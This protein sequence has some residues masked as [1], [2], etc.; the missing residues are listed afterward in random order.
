MISRFLPL[1]VATL[2]G[3]S[4]FAAPIEIPSPTG[5]PQSIASGTDPFLQALGERGGSSDF[6][7]RL[8]STAAALPVLGERT[9]DMAVSAAI[10]DQTRSRLFP[11]LGLD[12]IGART[13]TRDLQS[14]ATQIE[15]LSPLRR[16]DGIGSVDQLI[17]D[18]GA[19]SARIRAANAGNDAARADLDAARNI[20][21]LQLV[22]AWYEVLAAQTALALAQSNV[23]RMQLLAEGA[24]LRFERGVDSGGDVARARSYLA[25]AQSQKVSQSRRLRT[26]EASYIELFGS[27]PGP[28][29]R[30]DINTA[31]SVDGAAVR[32]ELISARAQ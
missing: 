1:T 13:I 27:S 30:P 23:D 7:T 20:A 3:Q 9:A 14:P 24:T 15:N 26:A 28:L 16:N 29:Q 5:W 17:S 31:T 11:S 10:R 19:T 6:V 8:S 12:F 22:A 32:P 2:L 18:F 21:L 4:A 25:A